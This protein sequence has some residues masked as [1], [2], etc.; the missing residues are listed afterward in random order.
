MTTEF[1]STQEAHPPPRTLELN[2]V[3]MA[4]TFVVFVGCGLF[5]ASVRDHHPLIA[6]LSPVVRKVAEA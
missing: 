1:A 2:S 6:A 3:F 5:A 4:M